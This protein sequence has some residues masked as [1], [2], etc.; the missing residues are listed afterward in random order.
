MANTRIDIGHTQDRLIG[1]L[2]QI[3]SIHAR[4]K[5]ITRQVRAQ[6]GIRREREIMKDANSVLYFV[7]QGM[8][9]VRSR[10][11]TPMPPPYVQRRVRRAV[12]TGSAV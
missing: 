4:K 1:N 7:S 5:G 3:D 6:Q 2:R 9:E 11:S 12:L 10:D 8:R